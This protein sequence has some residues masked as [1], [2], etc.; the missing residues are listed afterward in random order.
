MPKVMKAEM[1]RG[2]MP[3]MPKAMKVEVELVLAPT[4]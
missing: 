2:K 1:P 4:M 3:K